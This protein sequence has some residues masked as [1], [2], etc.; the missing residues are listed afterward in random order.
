MSC[1]VA[2]MQVTAGMRAGSGCSNGIEGA[3]TASSRVRFD[4]HEHPDVGV[5]VL[6]FPCSTPLLFPVAAEREPNNE[7][8]GAHPGTPGQ[9]L[10]PRRGYPRLSVALPD[11]VRRRALPS[12]VN[13]LPRRAPPPPRPRAPAGSRREKGRGNATDSGAA[14]DSTRSRSKAPCQTPSTSAG[15]AHGAIRS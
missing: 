1:A 11:Q 12:R 14:S 15:R 9:G 2:A 8:P 3:R 4:A 6:P 10:C 13:P 7:N 5:W